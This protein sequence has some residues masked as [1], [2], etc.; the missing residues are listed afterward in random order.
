LH[1]VGIHNNNAPRHFAAN[2]LARNGGAREYV[3][4]DPRHKVGIFHIRFWAMAD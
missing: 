2:S 3:W 1:T 4:P